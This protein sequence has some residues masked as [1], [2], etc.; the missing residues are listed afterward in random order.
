VNKFI[1][2]VA[3]LEPTFGGINLEDIKAPECFEIEEKLVER[4][5]IP[6][7]HDDQHGTAVVIAAGLTNAL[8]KAG[9]EL[10]TVKIVISGAGAAA[11]AGAKLLK[12][13]GAKNIWMF[14]SK[15]LITTSIDVNRYKKEFAREDAGSL[16]E[17]LVGADVFIG[18]SKA[19]LLTGEM[20]KE[21]AHTPIIF[22]M[23]NPVPEIMPDV[24][25]AA[26]ADVIMATGRS[27]FPNQVN[28]VL[29]FPFM[30]RGAFDV[31]AS[32][33][34]EDMKIAAVHALASLAEEGEII[35]SPFNPN[36]M[37]VAE[38]VSKAAIK[39]GV[40]RKEK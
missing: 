1:E 16:S 25:K 17:V 29:C 27:D 19:G 38:A 20:V 7:F 14:D 33:I 18:L 34:N 10:E 31:R 24:A 2:I 32:R 13:M 28:N 5:D 6:V 37:K 12:K 30:F 22:A 21:M 39:S 8:K 3:A 4:M 9:K 40:A 35:P 26:V 23:A 36:L 15:G 11:I